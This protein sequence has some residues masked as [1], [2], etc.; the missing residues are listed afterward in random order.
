M[1]A[2]SCESY[3]PFLLISPGIELPTGPARITSYIEGEWALNKRYDEILAQ[4]GTPTPPVT[5]ERIKGSK[6]ENMKRA[7]LTV[8]SKK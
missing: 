6:L 1:S 3:Y 7:V 4:A 8:L 5:K 2:R